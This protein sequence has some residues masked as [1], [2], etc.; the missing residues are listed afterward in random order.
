MAHVHRLRSEGA[1]V[2]GLGSAASRPGAQKVTKTEEIGRL[3]DVI[4]QLVS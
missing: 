3:A 1:D 4:A 2:I